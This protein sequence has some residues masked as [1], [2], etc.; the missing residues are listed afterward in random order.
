[1]NLTHFFATLETTSVW[2]QVFESKITKS[3]V[4]LDQFSPIK[5][6]NDTVIQ[7]PTLVSS[8]QNGISLDLSA[9]TF[10]AYTSAVKSVVCMEQISFPTDSRIDKNWLLFRKVSFRK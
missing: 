8:E 9:E 3:W 1:M 6:T 7:V 5:A 4:N 2:T 10:F